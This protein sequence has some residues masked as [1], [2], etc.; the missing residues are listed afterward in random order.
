M[1]KLFF[2]FY[3]L[4]SGLVNWAQCINEILE[5]LIISILCLNICRFNSM[6][7]VFHMN[8][9]RV[10]TWPECDLTETEHE[11]D[12]PG[13]RPPPHVLHPPE[14]LWP[15]CFCR[16][17]EPKTCSAR[18]LHRSFLRYEAISKFQEQAGYFRLFDTVLA[19][20][21]IFL[22]WEVT[23]L[24]STPRMRLQMWNCPNNEQ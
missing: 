12:P 20:T 4:A 19:Q 13:W 5:T 22:G 6:W 23:Q 14:G 3:N 9:T 11:F 7:S 16:T 8:N 17:S 24:C 21:Q 18:T 10:L 1:D 15:V 2:F